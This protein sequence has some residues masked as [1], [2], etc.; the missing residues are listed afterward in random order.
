MPRAPKELSDDAAQVWR[1]VRLGKERETVEEVRASGEVSEAAI[2]EFESW[3]AE[4][5]KKS[6]GKK[7]GKRAARAGKAGA[8]AAEIRRPLRRHPFAEEISGARD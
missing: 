4:K 1:R 8:C 6:G 7:K 5:E 2:A 3:L